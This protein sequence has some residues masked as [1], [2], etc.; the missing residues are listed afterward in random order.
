MR[1]SS[2]WVALLTGG[3]PLFIIPSGCPGLL[4]LAAGLRCAVKLFTHARCRRS[5]FPARVE[6]GTLPGPRRRRRRRRSALQIDFR[7]ITPPLMRRPQAARRRRR[8]RRRAQR[9]LQIVSIIFQ[10]HFAHPAAH[11]YTRTH[12]RSKMWGRVRLPPFAAARTLI[13]QRQDPQIVCLLLH[14]ILTHT[15]L[16]THTPPLPTHTQY[17]ISGRF[18]VIFQVYT[19]YFKCL[20]S[21]APEAHQFPPQPLWPFFTLFL[22]THPGNPRTYIQGTGYRSQ[23]QI[24]ILN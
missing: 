21:F 20:M 8:Q 6:D 16:L 19:K 23:I 10:K 7:F 1:G 13:C 17:V 12:T 2:E 22:A 15:P 14:A 3:V 18:H 9:A 11:P 24:Q 4:L 5:D